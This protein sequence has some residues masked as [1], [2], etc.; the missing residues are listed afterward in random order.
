MG[1]GYEDHHLQPVYDGSYDGFC[2][3]FNIKLITVRSV[4]FRFSAIVL[5]V[6]CLR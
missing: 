1:V 6:C 4:Y 2:V 5:L 3:V